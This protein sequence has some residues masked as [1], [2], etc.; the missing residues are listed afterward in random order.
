MARRDTLYAQYASFVGFLIE[1]YGMGRFAKLIDTLPE[2][3]VRTIIVRPGSRTVTSTPI[4]ESD[5]EIK[6]PEAD[7]EAVYG[8][9]IDLL[10]RE[11]LDLVVVPTSPKPAPGS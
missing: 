5:L 1:Q 7:Y 2:P 6:R 4:R 9:S 11:W 10:E 3:D 8:K